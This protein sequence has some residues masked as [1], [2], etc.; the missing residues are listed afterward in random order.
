MRTFSKRGG[1]TRTQLIVR[2][3]VA[4]GDG[5]LLPS[6]DEILNS[7]EAQRHLELTIRAEVLLLL[8]RTCFTGAHSP[9]LSKMC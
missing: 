5:Q 9:I 1:R 6:D 8:L 4:L 7:P 3:T 2:P